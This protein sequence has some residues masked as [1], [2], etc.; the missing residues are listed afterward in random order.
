MWT[1]VL[2]LIKPKFGLSSRFFTPSASVLI[3]TSFPD[4]N[5][6]S[7]PKNKAK[8]A[9]VE[10]IFKEYAAKCGIDRAA[11]P[12]VFKGEILKAHF[13]AN[14]ATFHL[15]QGI[16]NWKQGTMR[17]YDSGQLVYW[18]RSDGTVWE[19]IHVPLQNTRQWEELTY[20]RIDEETFK[21]EYS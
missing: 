8:R 21:K 20:E 4:G 14:R 19:V 13:I 9:E 17:I 16:D 2:P 10:K 15:S 5:Y 7:H 1:R 11:K 3:D 18:R 6:L 12:K